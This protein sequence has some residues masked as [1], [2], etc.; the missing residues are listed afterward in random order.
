MEGASL[1]KSLEQDL[2][3]LSHLLLLLGVRLELEVPVDDGEAALHAVHGQQG[4][5]GEILLVNHH[6]MMDLDRDWY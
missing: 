6:G 4:E 5:Y 2:Q 1:D 3:R